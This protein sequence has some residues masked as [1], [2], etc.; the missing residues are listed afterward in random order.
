MREFDEW[1]TAGSRDCKSRFLTA[2][3]RR[4]GSEMN[5]EDGQPHPL[6]FAKNGPPSGQGRGHPRKAGG[7]KF[8]G[9]GRAAS[10]ADGIENSWPGQRRNLSTAEAITY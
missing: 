5:L 3:R 4:Q 1:R 10:A 8:A 9:P 2:E 7:G 6:R